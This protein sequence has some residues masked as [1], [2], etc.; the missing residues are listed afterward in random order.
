MRRALLIAALI[1]T[2]SGSGLSYECVRPNPEYTRVQQ[3][4]YNLRSDLDS[5][6]YQ[7][8]SK[9]WQLQEAKER[10][11]NAQMECRKAKEQFASFNR[12]HGCTEMFGCILAIN[13]KCGYGQDSAS[14]ALGPTEQQRACI[15]SYQWLN[16]EH[17]RY[18]QNMDWICRDAEDVC[19][20]A[21]SV[22]S[23]IRELRSRYDSML[24]EIER[25]ERLLDRIPIEIPCD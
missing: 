4:I 16:A 6:N 1:G 11:R 10:C 21:K 19:R 3:K 25:L 20:D 14:L 2:L 7:I 15:Q 17:D 23:E 18:Q 13:R 12:Q 9:Y 22:E 24:M 5:T 8:D